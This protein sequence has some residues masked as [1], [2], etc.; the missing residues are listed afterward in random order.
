MLLL[1]LVFEFAFRNFFLLRSRPAAWRKHANKAMGAI[2]LH[3]TVEPML[4][5]LHVELYGLF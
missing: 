3:D 4:V 1:V 2:S 5:K